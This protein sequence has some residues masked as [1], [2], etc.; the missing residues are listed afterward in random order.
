MTRKDVLIRGLDSAVYRRAK[1]AAASKGVRLGKA[2]DEALAGW[3]KE[4]ENSGLDA[5]MDANLN[6]VRNNWNR[7]KVNKGKAVVVSDGRLQGVFPT[8]E[9][10]RATASRMKRVALVFVVDKPPVE[11]EIEFGP[12]LEIH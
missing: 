8:Y 10:A 4:V 3:A 9:E 11:R 1:A 12:E 2:L 5:E 6:F 7:I